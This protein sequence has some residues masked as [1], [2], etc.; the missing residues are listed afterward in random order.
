MHWPGAR[1]LSGLCPR[2]EDFRAV[3]RTAD[4]EGQLMT[5][6]LRHLLGT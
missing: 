2:F 4:P 6:A 3:R 1:E 5:P